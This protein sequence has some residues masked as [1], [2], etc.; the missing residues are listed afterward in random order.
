MVLVIDVVSD[1]EGFAPEY[2]IVRS[3]DYTPTVCPPDFVALV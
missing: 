1:D 2:C 3:S